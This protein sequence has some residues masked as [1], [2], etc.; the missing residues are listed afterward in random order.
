MS[1]EQEKEFEKELEKKIE[2]KF[3][4]GC[5][6]SNKKNAT[7]NGSAGAVWFLGF[8]GAVV[9][10]IKFA[11]GFWDGV[12]GVLKAFVWPAFLVY[13]AMKALGM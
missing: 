3:E 9:Y 4:G 2:E 5:F 11:D 10:Y 7:Q 6:G 12:L 1:T 8:I 13:E